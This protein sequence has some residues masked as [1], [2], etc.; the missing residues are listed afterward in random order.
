MTDRNTEL[1]VEI[2]GD[3]ACSNCM[4]KA[5]IA[6]AHSLYAGNPV[7][8][9]VPAEVHVT[10]DLANALVVQA[11]LAGCPLKSLLEGVTAS[12]GRNEAARNLARIMSEARPQPGATRH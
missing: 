5:H 3:P 2:C 11:L 6:L 10:F 7:K 4:A 8:H 12:Y 1:H 9:P